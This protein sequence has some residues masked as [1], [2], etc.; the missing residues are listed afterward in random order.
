MEGPRF[1]YDKAFMSSKDP[2]LPLASAPQKLGLRELFNETADF[3][4]LITRDGSGAHTILAYNQDSLDKRAQLYERILQAECPFTTADDRPVDLRLSHKRGACVLVGS[5]KNLNVEAVEAARKEGAYIICMGNAVACYR[6]P[7]M[8]IGSKPPNMYTPH[9]FQTP[10][11]LALSPYRYR[12]ERMW[13]IK[14]KSFMSETIAQNPGNIF[15]KAQHGT[16]WD[17]FGAGT[18]TVSNLRH[19]TTL[20]LSMSIAALMGFDIIYMTGVDCGGDPKEYFCFEET[21]SA[22]Q[23]NH[24]EKVYGKLTTDFHG[25]YQYFTDYG[26]RIGSLGPTSLYMP[27][28]P[29]ELVPLI[30]RQ[31][32]SQFKHSPTMI[33]I[34]TPAAHKVATQAAKDRVR[35]ALYLPATFADHIEDYAAAFPETMDTPEIADGRK[36][37]K[38]ALDK[39]GCSGCAK[40]RYM[41]KPFKAFTDSVGAGHE[42]LMKMWEEKAPD[43]YIIRTGNTYIYRTDKKNLEEEA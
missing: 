37:L 43:K 2:R 8:W 6:E 38:L 15:F 28:Y 24:K 33:G 23:L 19:N 3:D 41:A 22:M 17:F 31:V 29:P 20:T 7:H 10:G 5:G 30:M 21:I 35:M 11:I 4:T 32:G 16:L 1:G 36:Q 26:I 14:R 27:E 40:N 42:G 25:I 39:G 9:P 34:S 13:N 12:A 18:A